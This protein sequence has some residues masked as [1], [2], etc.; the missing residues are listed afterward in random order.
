MQN[1]RNNGAFAFEIVTHNMHDSDLVLRPSRH[2]PLVSLSAAAT[3]D[4]RGHSQPC[5]VAFWGIVVAV[6]RHGIGDVHEL[7]LQTPH[8]YRGTRSTA[9]PECGVD[10]MIAA[11]KRGASLSCGRKSSSL[12]RSRMNWNLLRSLRN[13]IDDCCIHMTRL[14]DEPLLF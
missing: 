13:S 11:Q 5:V 1:A 8:K 10:A 4:V 12:S 6:T 2:A 9:G 3:P 7:L 14:L